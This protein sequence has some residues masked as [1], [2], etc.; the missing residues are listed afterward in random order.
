M[1]AAIQG[2]NEA[3]HE[4]G[5]PTADLHLPRHRRSRA[6]ANSSKCSCS[7]PWLKGG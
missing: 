1:S 2:T 6:W 3:Y 7:P 4:D 5:R